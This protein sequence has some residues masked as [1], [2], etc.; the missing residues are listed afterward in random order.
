M[1]REE[2]LALDQRFWSKVVKTDGCWIWQGALASNGYGR[3]SINNRRYP[4][5]R[6]A[7][8]DAIG[9]IEDGLVM[10]HLCRNRA[11]VNPLHLEPVT[12]QENIKRGIGGA[13]LKARNDAITECPRGHPYTPE[14]TRRDRKGSRNC[15]TCDKANAARW[16]EKRRA[17]AS[18]LSEKGEG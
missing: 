5:H 8:Q 17:R 2:M 4:A 13:M 15:R 16:T 7:Y 9:P 14:N 12:N 18:L 11:C 3:F 6:L 10:D 1:T